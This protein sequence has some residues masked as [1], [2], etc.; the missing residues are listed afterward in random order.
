MTLP[1][2]LSVDAMLA[3][4]GPTGRGRLLALCAFAGDGTSSR[5]GLW[6]LLG[7]PAMGLQAVQSLVQAIK[8]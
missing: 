5:T 7:R 3:K 6:R 2:S 1:G 8:G 4:A